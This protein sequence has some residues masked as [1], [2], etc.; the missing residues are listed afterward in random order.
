MRW[1][2]KRFV[3]WALLLAAAVVGAWLWWRGQKPPD[4]RGPG[5]GWGPEG[6]VRLRVS[7]PQKDERD[8]TMLR[9]EVDVWNTTGRALTWPNTPPMNSVNPETNFLFT[10]FTDEHPE[11]AQVAAVQEAYPD[12][13]WDDPTLAP[14]QTRRLVFLVRNE[15]LTAGAKAVQVSM[16][17]TTEF[18]EDPSALWS[19]T[20][21]SPRLPLSE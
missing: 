4:R 13:P 3:A 9:F 19:G 17:C 21:R 12:H 1:R 10:F 11:G 5:E 15:P 8:R 20:A 6:E 14:G 18:A 16:A 2:P 7:L